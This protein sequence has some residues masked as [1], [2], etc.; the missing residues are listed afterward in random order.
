MSGTRSANYDVVIYG[1]TGHTGR[2]V[3]RQFGP[4]AAGG[5]V[6]WAVAARDPTKLKALRAFLAPDVG[7]L[8][9]DVGDESAIA[10]L[11]ASTRVVLNM[12]GPYAR[13]AEPL[14]RACA[15]LGVDYVDVTGETPHVRRLIDRYHHTAASTGARIVPFCGFDSVP[16][17]LG[18]LLLVEHFRARGLATRQVKGFVRAFGSLN[19]G[20]T[21][22][23]LELWRNPADIRAM[24]DPL[25]LNPPGPSRA[26]GTPPDPDPVFPVRDLDLNRW[27]APFFMAPI[28]TRV[29]RR[30]R[31][32]AAEA[33]EDYGRDFQ[34]QEFWDPG[35]P[36]SMVPAAAVA[37][38]LAMYRMMAGVPNAAELLA[39][40]APAG[41]R[42]RVQGD[43][44]HDFFRSLYVATAADGSKAW[45]E[46]AGAGDPSNGAT[47]KIVCECA[48]ALVLERDPPP[49]GERRGGIL[50]PAVALGTPLANRLREVGMNVTC[51]S[52]RPPG[53]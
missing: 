4:R 5:T 51:P 29:V 38:S 46:I 45:A 30:S 17:D 33:G 37:W 47:A 14:V 20:T 36:V 43:Q 13:C 50:T 15:R 11:V 21:A 1:A 7:A 53:P 26:G 42:V 27:V 10:R 19:A 16:S 40:L 3:V 8:V 18:T 23:T 25:L 28:N 44:P 6:R 35:G 41:A 48:L 32:L 22:T 39:P 49:G 2:Q 9:A 24:E 34:Y 12:A 31:A 52:T